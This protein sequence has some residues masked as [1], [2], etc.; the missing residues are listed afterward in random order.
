MKK[1]SFI[2]VALIFSAQIAFANV[3]N[4]PQKLEYIVPK[5]PQFSEVSCNFKQQKQMPN[6]V[7]L[8]S[9]GE[10][11]FNSKTGVVFKTTSPIKTVNAYSPKEYNQINDVINAIANRK[12]S[13][14][15]NQFD[16]YYI[17]EK[18]WEFAMKPKSTSQASKYLKSIEIY[19]ANR[20]SKMVITTTNSV[21]TTIWFY[22]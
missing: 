13:K 8:N 12:Y 10:F 20:I 11:Y 3:F 19:G 7:I 22:D 9:S 17:G 2:F 16:F 5:L 4:S 18:P 21:K 1:L 15:E 6:N 14:I